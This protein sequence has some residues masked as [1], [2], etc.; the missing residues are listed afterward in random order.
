MYACILSVSDL[1]L[2][3]FAED[4]PAAALQHNEDIRPKGD[5][6]LFYN[7]YGKKPVWIT[8][9]DTFPVERFQHDY[10]PLTKKTRI[11]GAFSYL[12]HSSFPF[13]LQTL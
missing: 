7:T 11:H 6:P 8:M 5:L 13:L 3:H 2:L 1:F 10:R 9:K 12:R 4:P